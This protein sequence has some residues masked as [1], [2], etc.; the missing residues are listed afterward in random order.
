MP[1]EI[2][3]QS[4]AHP[5]QQLRQKCIPQMGQIESIRDAEGSTFCAGTWP[6]AD[7]A[8]QARAERAA[9]AARARLRLV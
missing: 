8:G 5:G 9:E 7:S 4:S 1:P 6:L 2:R 3:S